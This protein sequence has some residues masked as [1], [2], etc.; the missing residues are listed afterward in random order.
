M[1]TC[2]NLP[3]SIPLVI[4]Y[5]YKSEDAMATISKTPS[6][7]GKAVIRKSGWPTTIKTFHTKRDAQD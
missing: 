6:N 5:T 4:R 2:T 1:I 7:T 3:L